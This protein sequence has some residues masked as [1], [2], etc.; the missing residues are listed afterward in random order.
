MIIRERSINFTYISTWCGSLPSMSGVQL[1]R[2]WGCASIVLTF[3]L[4][5]CV[6]F[7]SSSICMTHSTTFVSWTCCHNLKCLHFQRLHMVGST[8]ELKVCSVMFHKLVPHHTWV[9]CKHINSACTKSSKS[10][11]QTTYSI[12]QITPLLTSRAHV[13]KH[14]HNTFQT[15]FL[16]FVRA[17]M[18]QIDFQWF[19]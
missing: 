15:R 13:E 1:G 10:S 7:Q 6:S 2:S 3:V 12:W 8:Y 5:S 9:A 4:I 11:L 17:L 16:T 14:P 19:G 18:F